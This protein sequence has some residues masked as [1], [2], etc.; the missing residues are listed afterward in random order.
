MSNLEPQNTT[1]F[2]D[3]VRRIRAAIAEQFG[4]DVDRLCDHL[5][6]VESDY[7]E[8]RG[9]YSGIS[10]EAASQVV[11]SWGDD[12]LRRDDPLIDEVRAIRKK[13]SEKRAQ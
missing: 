11:A 3:E 5:R 7:D 10:E 8:R 4:N 6:S 12:A 13:L 1:S 2:V 9:V